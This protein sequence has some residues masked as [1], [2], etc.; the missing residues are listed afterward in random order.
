MEESPVVAV[1]ID[2]G[3]VRICFPAVSG[4]VFVI[5]LR[6]TGIVAAASSALSVTAAL[7]DL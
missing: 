6:S 7:V 4:S 2:G 1:T 5:D 3:A